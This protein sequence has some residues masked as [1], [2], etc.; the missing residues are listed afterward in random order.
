MN[1]YD[2]YKPLRNRVRGFSLEQ[3]LIDAWELSL[4]AS[5]I[6]P[7]PQ[8]RMRGA[9]FNRPQPLMHPWIVDLLVRELILE[10]P[11]RGDRSLL[12]WNH[13]APLLND[14]MH[15]ENKSFGANDVPMDVMV[16]VHRIAHRQFHWQNGLNPNN[17]SRALRIF[18]APAVDALFQAEYGMSVQQNILVG[19]LLYSHFQSAHTFQDPVAFRAF[20]ISDDAITRYLSRCSVDLPTLRTN[21]RL[22]QRYDH[23]WPYTMNWLVN[24][25]LIRVTRHD[26]P[27][28][29]CPIPRHLINRMTSGLFFDIGKLPNFE[30]PY[31]ASFSRYVGDVLAKVGHGQALSLTPE[32]RFKVR[33]EDKDGPDWIWSDA[34][35]V[36]FVEAK[37]KR[38]TLEAKV[39]STGK[40]LD[41]QIE[42]IA[43]A[44]VQNYK[45]L[46]LGLD[47]HMPHWKPDSRPVFP[48]VVTI[49]DWHLL[50]FKAQN[51]LVASVRTRLASAGLDPTIFDR[52][53]FLVVSVAELE[54]VS[55]VMA[56]VAISTVLSR[57]LSES[58]FRHSGLG[59]CVYQDFRGESRAASHN[60]F[61][62]DLDDF[63]D[64]AKQDYLRYR[65]QS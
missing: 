25:P 17:Y 48:V 5:E 52:Y 42:V 27:A 16:E 53:P 9:P 59:Q 28:W 2:I 10:A 19:A 38:I 18:G 46:Q 43:A 64:K 6:R 8:G 63:F 3:S 22:A 34:S 45:N 32:Q 39:G 55:Q 1:F 65:A 58:T 7:L 24:Q 35:G 31:G 15:V 20:G 56:R 14:I 33:S 50:G 60:L 12:Q 51:S 37:T 30:N 21:L 49:D 54:W 57:K 4:D 40:A 62:D 11:L 47:G 41:E 13:F 44:V 36:M 23:D 26:K 29:L 61:A